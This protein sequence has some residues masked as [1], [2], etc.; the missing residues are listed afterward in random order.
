MSGIGG[1]TQVLLNIPGKEP[2]SINGST[3]SPG[4]TPT[5]FLK[6]SLN[7]YQRSTV[8]STLKTLDFLYRKYSSRQLTWREL[9]EPAIIIAREGI[10]PGEFRSKVYHKY[11]K[12]LH[13]GLPG[14]YEYIN[15]V[16][17]Q[18]F[19]LP[20][21]AN[22]LQMIAIEGPDVFYEGAIARSIIEDMSSNGGWI[23]EDDLL[24]LDD[25]AELPSV[26]F[27]Y[28]ELDVY[29]QP[30]P[31]GGWVIKEIL[32]SLSE[33]HSSADSSETDLELL[34]HALNYGHNRR[35]VDA[36]SKA[37][38]N[39]E[40]THFSVMDRNGLALSVTSS[41]NAYYGGGVAN[42][43]Y[44]FLY[45][46]YM[47][48]FNFEDPSDKYALG[49]G[50]MAYSSMSPTIVKKNGEII[51]VIGSPGSSRIISTVAQLIDVYAVGKIEATELLNI[52]RV[53]AIN[54]MVYF[55]RD[56]LEKKAKLDTLEWIIVKPNKD[57]GKSGLNAYFG[58][59]HAIIK[60]RRS[61][62]AL[63]DP[64]RDGTALTE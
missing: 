2:I 18:V 21:L 43:E 64:R 58:G 19:R 16:G 51:M 47:D 6:D 24:L 50:K 5:Y 32:Q 49:P 27:K 11:F 61:Y 13:N 48:D 34:I 26:R 56:F 41:I 31:C 4:A 33:L 46:S 57:L 37:L 63:A 53:H 22:T 3:I 7:D 1:G 12:K 62:I 45:N 25:P 60:D 17:Q 30:E 39:G 59:V 42:P 15:D 40:T 8:P 38:D 10:I 54:N 20:M 9:I 36:Q 28:N 35:R 14:T 29:T 44:G 52:P 55:E 23:Q